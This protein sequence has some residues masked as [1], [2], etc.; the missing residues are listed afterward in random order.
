MGRKKEN[1]DPLT[2]SRKNSLQCDQGR[3]NHSRVS[4]KREGGEKRM[5]SLSSGKKERKRK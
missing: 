2:V 3:G 4:R 5:V 1:L